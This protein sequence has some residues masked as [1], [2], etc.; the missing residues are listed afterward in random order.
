MPCISISILHHI[1]KLLKL[2][3]L[4]SFLS[5][6]KQ[7]I[8]LIAKKL[9]CF[10]RDNIHSFVHSSIYSFILSSKQRWL[11]KRFTCYAS[12]DAH[13]YKLFFDTKAF[14]HFFDTYYI[15]NRQSVSRFCHIFWYSR[16]TINI[17]F[18]NIS[19]SG[20]VI[21]VTK[22]RS[23]STISAY[24]IL[25]ST[26]FIVFVQ[27]TNF[28]YKYFSHSGNKLDKFLDSQQFSFLLKWWC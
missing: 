14:Y 15:H 22:N 28:V 23:I 18:V 17:F 5:D 1:L 24:Q 11:W 20:V 3:S 27:W 4:D 6:G 7:K 21:I 19:A 10:Q 13:K 2:S 25:H 12:K 16:K 8:V 9:I 26:E